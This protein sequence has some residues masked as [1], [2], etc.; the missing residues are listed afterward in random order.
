[1]NRPQAALAM[2][3]LMPYIIQGAHLGSLKMKDITQPQFLLLVK[4]HTNGTCSM[5]VLATHMQVKLP[6]MTGM[7]N[8][9]V[10]AGCLKRVLKEEDRRQVWIALTP[11]GHTF[12]KHFQGILKKRWEDVLAILDER[13]V[14]QFYCIVDKLTKKLGGA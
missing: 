3:H 7:V 4:L 2:S 13:E 5:N 8:R 9:L 12:L 10:K 6:T 14:K 11:K 1:M